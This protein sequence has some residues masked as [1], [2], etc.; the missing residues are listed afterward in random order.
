MVTRKRKWR[1]VFFGF[2]TV[3]TAGVFSQARLNAAPRQQE[4]APAGKPLDYEFFKAR[5]EP[6]FLKTRGAHARCYACHASNTGPQYLVKLSPGATTWNEEQSRKIFQN[7]S[8][9]IDMDEPMKSRFLIH[10]LSPLAGGDSKYIHS[11]GR[12]FESKDD[13]DWKNMAAWANGATLTSD[14]A[15]K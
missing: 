12:Q 15:T 4:A 10:P 7:V 14:S 2:V 8:K 3:V 13:P 11:G 6:I 1:A 5:V 9:L